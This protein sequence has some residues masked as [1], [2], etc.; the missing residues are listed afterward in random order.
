MRR[1]IW[2]RSTQSGLAL[3]VILFAATAVAI[4]DADSVTTVGLGARGAKTDTTGTRRSARMRCS[5][6]C[7]TLMRNLLV[8]REI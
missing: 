8:K 5:R 2:C 1:R 7:C 6:P 3:E 4:G